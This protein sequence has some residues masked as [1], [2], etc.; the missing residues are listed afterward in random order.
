MVNSVTDLDAIFSNFLPSS[1]SSSSNNNNSYQHQLR[2]QMQM[3]RHRKAVQAQPGKSPVTLMS[4][5]GEPA[6]SVLPAAAFTNTVHSDDVPA[7]ISTG[8]SSSAATDRTSLH[9]GNV[10]APVANQ[11]VPTASGMN[12]TDTSKLSEKRLSTLDERVF[13]KPTADWSKSHIQVLLDVYEKER[14]KF[15]TRGLV[16]RKLWNEVARKVN[17][18]TGQHFSG[19]HCENNRAADAMTTAISYWRTHR[20]IFVRQFH[21]TLRWKVLMRGYRRAERVKAEGKLNAEQ[22]RGAHPLH[23]RIQSILAQEPPRHLPISVR[24]IG[25]LDAHTLSREE[26]QVW[27]IADSRRLLTHYA[28]LRKRFRNGG[29]ASLPQTEWDKELH[30]A[31]GKDP[32]PEQVPLT[33]SQAAKKRKSLQEEQSDKAEE[34]KADGGDANMS[35]PSPSIVHLESVPKPHGEFVAYLASLI[36]G[37]S[38][39]PLRD[40]T[41]QDIL[42]YVFRFRKNARSE[43]AQQWS[44]QQPCP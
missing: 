27:S 18:Q 4:G 37:F 17:S 13:T 43:R 40:K 20:P 16:S 42:R 24:G 5:S 30:A 2:Q 38:A 3:G 35:S 7:T 28:E 41:M 26:R 44:S 15:V 19:F 11:L 33:P 6:G 12:I 39:G 1:S 32:L 10:C 36:D 34:T 31:L 23:E 14:S 25:N 9:H 29:C 8:V 21:W 22:F